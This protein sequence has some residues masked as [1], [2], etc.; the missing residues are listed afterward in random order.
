MVSIIS[1]ARGSGPCSNKTSGLKFTQNAFESDDVMIFIYLVYLFSLAVVWE[2]ISL[3][4][5]AVCR[6]PPLVWPTNAQDCVQSGIYVFWSSKGNITLSVAGIGLLCAG[7]QMFRDISPPTGLFDPRH[8]ESVFTRLFSSLCVQ[9]LLQSVWREPLPRAK[10][11]LFTA[12]RTR[13]VICK[14]VNQTEWTLNRQKEK[15]KA[16]ILG[17]W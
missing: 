7:G 1:L 12:E 3:E 9:T 16:C 8:R 4:H 6:F 15:N 13:Y 17:Q 2:D 14:A 11:S 10:S 5:R